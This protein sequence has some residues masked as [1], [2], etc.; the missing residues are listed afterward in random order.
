MKLLSPGRRKAV[1][2]ALLFCLLVAVW[3]MTRD[4]G[5]NVEWLTEPPAARRS[6]LG[7]LGQWKQPVKA[8]LLRVKYW[9]FGKPQ[10]V[11]IRADFFKLD[12]PAAISNLVS[13]SPM[14]SNGAGAQGWIVK[15]ATALRSSLTNPPY[16]ILAA[17][18]VTLFDGMQA[19]VFVGDGVPVPG[20]VQNVRFHLDLSPQVRGDF[21]DLTSFFLATEQASNQTN[22][23][24][25]G[26]M[27]NIAFTRTNAAFGVRV[28]LP[29]GASVFL[30]ASG[31][32]N[33]QGKTVGT[34]LSPEVWPRK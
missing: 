22:A 30:L 1:F 12:S 31:L 25:G 24:G 18:T 4:A 26:N 29:K 15:N 9:L 14:F 23:F 10:T 5:G 6:R 7:F 17:S 16:R 19:E 32:T 8:Q 28:H 34:L 21:L 20:G 3:F 13:S 27:T 33:D 2:A 11:T